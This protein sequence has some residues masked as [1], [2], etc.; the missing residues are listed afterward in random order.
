MQNISKAGVK[1][2]ACIISTFNTHKICDPTNY[3]YLGRPTSKL[4]LFSVSLI[5]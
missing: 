5:A 3:I 2:F 1:L 4:Y